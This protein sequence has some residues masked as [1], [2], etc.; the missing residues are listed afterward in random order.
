MH[1]IVNPTPAS[2]E[3]DFA[4]MVF[5]MYPNSTRLKTCPFEEWVNLLAQSTIDP[6]KNPAIRLVD[7]YRGV[8]GKEPRKLTSFKAEKA[9]KTLQYVGALNEGWVRNW[10]Q[11]WGFNEH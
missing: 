3:K 1:H 5:A 4:P 9:S 11:Q 7:F 6:E 2:W 8:N 10:M